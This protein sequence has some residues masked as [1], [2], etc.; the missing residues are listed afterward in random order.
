MQDTVHAPNSGSVWGVRIYETSAELGAGVGDCLGDECICRQMFVSF[1]WYCLP[2]LMHSKL[3]PEPRGRCYRY[4]RFQRDY[5][6]ARPRHGT[7]F[8]DESLCYDRTPQTTVYSKRNQMGLRE[9]D[10]QS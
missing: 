6:V 3:Q 8:R 9:P 2:S 4:S 5:D 1:N 10:E 7:E